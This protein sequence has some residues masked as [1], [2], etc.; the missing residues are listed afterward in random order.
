MSKSTLKNQPDM[1]KLVNFSEEEVNTVKEG[2]DIF[3]RGNSMISLEE[4]LEFLKEMNIHE[5]NPTVFSIIGSL[6][7]EN[8]KGINFKNFMEAFQSAIGSLDSKS[9]V[10]KLFDSLFQFFFNFYEMLA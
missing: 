8:P 7:Q 9:G 3:D 1:A 6:A 5:N 4:M 2:F 10:K